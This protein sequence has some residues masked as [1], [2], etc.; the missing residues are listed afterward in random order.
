M[1]IKIQE[2]QLISRRNVDESFFPSQTDEEERSST[3]LKECH[4]DSGAY[5]YDEGSRAYHSPYA[6]FTVVSA[7]CPN[8]GITSSAARTINQ[9]RAGNCPET[10]R[11]YNKTEY[12]RLQ[13][14]NSSF[15]QQAILTP[16]SADQMGAEDT[17]NLVQSSKVTDG[18]TPQTS[19]EMP[20]KEA[21]AA[22]LQAR[23][24]LQN[25]DA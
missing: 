13:S 22:S 5:S 20:K 8:S 9:D 10:P 15:E 2:P 23:R 24:R 4:C 21:E 6:P 7:V 16:F 3:V 17:F 18:Q 25:R 12:S 11:C 14:V 19:N 1:T